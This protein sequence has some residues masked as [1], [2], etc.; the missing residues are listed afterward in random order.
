MQILLKHEK[1]IEDCIQPCAGEYF[2]QQKSVCVI[3]TKTTAPMFIVNKGTYQL[4]QQ[5][6]LFQS[7]WTTMEAYD[8][9]EYTISNFGYTG[10]CC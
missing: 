1:T 8:T 9:E 3:D 10:D 4:V 5:C 2:Q 7:F 6:C